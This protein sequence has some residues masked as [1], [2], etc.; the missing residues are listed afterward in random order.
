VADSDLA[1]AVEVDTVL[2][3]DEGA[4]S[5]RSLARVGDRGDD[6]DFADAAV[7]RGADGWR[8]ERGAFFRTARPLMRGA[9]FYDAP[10]PV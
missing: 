3:E 7:T 1:R 4:D 6:E 8:A 5:L 2:R 10:P 9:V